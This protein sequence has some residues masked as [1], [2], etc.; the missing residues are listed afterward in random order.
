MKIQSIS[1]IQNY[2]IKNK[3]K[4]NTKIPYKNDSIS[5]SKS[6]EVSFNGFQ[7]LQLKLQA[8]NLEKNGNTAFHNASKMQDDSHGI[9][10]DALSF[11][12][13]AKYIQENAPRILK[14]AHMIY[15][16]GQANNFENMTDKKTGALLR[17]YYDGDNGDFIIEDHGDREKTLRKII[18]NKDVVMVMELNSQTRKMDAFVFD[19]NTNELLQYIRNI[20]ITLNGY[21][22]EKQ[23]TYDENKLSSC[24]LK[25]EMIEEGFEKSKK[26]YSFEDD[27]LKEF[28]I[29]WLYKPQHSTYHGEH[30][31]FNDVLLTKV[32]TGLEEIYGNE[33]K[34]LEEYIFQE[35]ASLSSFAKNV[36]ISKTQN[37]TMDSIFKFGENGLEKIYLGVDYDL[38]N[39]SYSSKKLF[40]YDDLEPLFCKLDYTHNPNG[41]ENFSKNISLKVQ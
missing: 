3:I 35:D 21:K 8:R 29:D 40:I 19:S 33:T 1:N 30:F 7:E 22:A 26:R 39:K 23:F 6:K 25:Y 5:L 20:K 12:E 4:N 36:F 16:H 11:Q 31:L 10:L 38:K 2:K 13:E 34:S 37:S 28:S 18:F 41:R 24:D 17:Q 32:S 14:R 15:N 27:K 9:L